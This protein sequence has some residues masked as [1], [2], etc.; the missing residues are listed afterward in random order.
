MTL[1]NEGV[2]II[3]THEQVSL[4]EKI[5]QALDMAGESEDRKQMWGAALRKLQNRLNNGSLIPSS[6]LHQC[7]AWEKLVCGSGE[8][9]V[10][11]TSDQIATIEFEI[12]QFLDAAIKKFGESNERIFDT[13]EVGAL[14]E[15]SFNVV[16]AEIWLRAEELRTEFVDNLTALHS[17]KEL[18]LASLFHKLGGSS[19]KTD[20]DSEQS[21]TTQKI[22]NEIST[23]VMDRLQPILRVSKL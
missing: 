23:F 22:N 15:L 19:P 6:I 11:I 10:D 5:Q 13:K 2:Q 8:D 16:D 4:M 14:L 18:K 9:P 1:G 12:D 7:E 17:R 3:E 20:L 21:T